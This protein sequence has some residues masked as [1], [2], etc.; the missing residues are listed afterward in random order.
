MHLNIE[1]WD[2]KPAWL[3]LTAAERLAPLGAECIGSWPNDADVDQPRGK[4]HGSVFIFPDTHAVVDFE[5]I[6]RG[7]GWDDHFDQLNASGPI[8]GFENVMAHALAR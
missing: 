8:D 7:F 6:A 1:M 5:A 2:A 3:A 4:R